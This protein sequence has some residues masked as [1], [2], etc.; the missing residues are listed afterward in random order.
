MGFNLNN[1]KSNISG[2]GYLKP[3]A[4]EVALSIPPILQNK[5][6]E[7][8]DGTEKSL[9]NVTND[10]LRYRIDQVK[11]PGVSLLSAEVQ[12]FGFGPT[13]KIPFNSYYHDTTFSILLDKKADLLHFWYDWMRTIFEFNGSESGIRIPKYVSKYKSE[14]TSTMQIFLYD[15]VGNIVKKINL[16]E[17]FP[18]SLLEM[19]LAW[20][21]KGDLVRLATSITYSQF[22]IEGGGLKD[23]LVTY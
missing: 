8:Y 10:I 6:L 5:K 23:P 1:F 18:S 16:Y 3:H 11:I 2:Y 15:Q 19:P 4:F 20:N 13:Q 21:D 12:R 22:T 7:S 17:A 14:Y 9:F